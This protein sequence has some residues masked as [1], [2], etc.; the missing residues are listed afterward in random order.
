M[1]YH[2]E[3]LVCKVIYK[4]SVSEYL[5]KSVFR[6]ILLKNPCSI[7]G[8]RDLT[9]VRVCSIFI[10]LLMSTPSP[11]NP[12]CLRHNLPPRSVLNAIDTSITSFPKKKSVDIM[13]ACSLHLVVKRLVT[14]LL[15]ASAFPL[16]EPR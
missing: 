11:R 10:N 9:F 12:I 15:T 16:K 2:G 7:Q 6:L 8:V 3:V 1:K 14:F 13:L 5:V 4:G